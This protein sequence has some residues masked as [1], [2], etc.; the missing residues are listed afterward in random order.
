MLSQAI[1][2][3]IN[4]FSK[5]PG[6]GPK[7]AERLVFYLIKQ[8]KKLLQEFG[9]ALLHAGDNLRF[10]Q[11][12]GQISEQKI[13]PICQD[14][15]RNHSLICVIA[16][17]ADILPLE[18]AQEFNGVYH[19]LKRTLNQTEGITPEKLRIQELEKRI[20]N[21]NI[22]EIIL[23]LNPNIEGETTTNYLSKLLKKK[24]P[25]LKITRLARG[26]P[27]GSDLEYADE[28]TLANAFKG[29]TQI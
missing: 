24:Y 14:K 23:A 22:Q 2:N 12:C 28:I 29:R 1:Q 11:A 19:V 9:N 7:T 6:I 20:S 8:D 3:L 4:Q 16:E 13:C 10:C 18:K 5:L 17:T 25:H 27:Q 15:Q 26:L 21:N